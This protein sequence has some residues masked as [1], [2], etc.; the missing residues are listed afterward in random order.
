LR[1]AA[2]L[3]FK[4]PRLYKN[5]LS[6]QAGVARI[7]VFV[8]SAKKTRVWPRSER[9]AGPNTTTQSPQWEVKQNDNKISYEDA[10]HDPVLCIS[11]H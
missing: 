6:N 1:Y 10:D 4:T 11:F 8:Q 5:N 7:G 2:N 3:S 9:G